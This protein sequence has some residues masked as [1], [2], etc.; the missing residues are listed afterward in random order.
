MPAIKAIAYRRPRLLAG[1]YRLYEESGGL[2]L[3]WN[4]SDNS[5]DDSDDIDGAV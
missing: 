2:R 5:P 3:R 1:S 4:G